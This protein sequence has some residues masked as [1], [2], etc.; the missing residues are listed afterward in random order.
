MRTEKAGYSSQRNKG[1]SRGC[2]GC[3]AHPGLVCSSRAGD[4]WYR[5]PS[6]DFDVY[7]AMWEATDLCYV[8]GLSI[9]CCHPKSKNHDFLKMPAP[10]TQP[11]CPLSCFEFLSS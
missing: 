1:W 7:V 8:S 9:L 3:E 6:S 4:L 5:L 10:F 2:T 11:L